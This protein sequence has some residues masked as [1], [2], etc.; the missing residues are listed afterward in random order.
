MHIS[1]SILTKI[2]IILF[3][4]LPLALPATAA[5][6]FDPLEKTCEQTPGA[7]VCVESEKTEEPL[8][9]TAG[10]LQRVSNVLAIV[11]AVIA[12]IIIVVAGITMTLS[13]GDSGKVRSS[14]DAI[15]YALVGIVII[16]IARS[17][18]LFIINRVG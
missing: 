14:R 17:I 3:L 2:T 5:A 7:T 10:V 15:I 11:G 4:L 6:Q 8:V 18:V 12:V 13:G 9:G 1:K 16:L